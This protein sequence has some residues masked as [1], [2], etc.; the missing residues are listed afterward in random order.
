MKLNSKEKTAYRATKHFKALRLLKL[1]ECN[2]RCSLCG[3]KK[4]NRNL[5]LHHVNPDKYNEPDEDKFT[6]ILCSTC[7]KFIEQKIKVLNNTKNPVTNN[8]IELYRLLKPYSS[9]LNNISLD[10]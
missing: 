8:R 9:L 3:V 10:R 2:N 5:Q 7:H 4:S 1:V 6:V